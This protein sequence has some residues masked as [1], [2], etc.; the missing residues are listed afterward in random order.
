M[1]DFCISRKGLLVWR[2]S[3]FL[4]SKFSFFLFFFFCCCCLV[5]WFFCFVLSLVF[6]DRVSLYSPGCPGTHSVDQAG[7]ELRNPPA[8]ASRA[9]G[10]KAC[11]TTPGPWKAQLVKR[12]VNKHKVLLW[13]SEP[14]WNCPGVE[15]CSVCLVGWFWLGVGGCFVLFC[16]CLFVVQTTSLC[17]SVKPWLSWNLLCRPHWPQ[18]WVLGLKA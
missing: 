17:F 2:D 10:L 6:R 7:L 15:A 9:L 14:L 18:T 11:P 5:G 13:S 8:S 12:L 16:F 1:T 3:S 4:F